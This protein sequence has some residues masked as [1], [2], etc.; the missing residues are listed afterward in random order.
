MV[1]D[2]SAVPVV[3][4]VAVA[5][6][7]SGTSVTLPGTVTAIENSPI[8]ARAPGYVARRYVDIGSRVK[9]G[10]LLAEV[11]AP[12]LDQQVEQARAEVAQASASLELAR[13]ELARWKSMM[14]DS[15]VTAAELDQKQAAFN[16]TTATL[17]SAKANLN[18]LEQ[19]QRY[20][21]VVAPFS[22]VITARN[23]DV[24]ALVGTAGAVSGQLPSGAGSATGS[25][26]QMARVDTLAIFISVPEDNSNAIR[27]GKVASVTIPA[28]P[29]DTL[30]G[31]ITR[32]SNALDPAA[33][34]LLTEV[35]VPNPKGAFLPGSYAQVTLALEQGTTGIR[36][37]AAGLIVRD[38]PPKVAVIG[39]DSIARYV[40]V[41]I[42]RDYGAWVEVK[43]GLSDGDLVVLNPPDDLK[44]GQKVRPK[45]QAPTDKP[46]PAPVPAGVKPGKP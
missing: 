30:R 16:T 27:V 10:Q 24:G 45:V 39:T 1:A 12:E 8:Y 37:P 15:A 34:T 4:V 19:L 35:D 13:Q 25:L 20:K 22:G 28:V 38:G 21:N 7:P 26:F 42:G 3:G 5:P 43:N 46:V 6:S 14:S 18:Q 33:R 23:V 17:N 2:N 41:T 29:G 31:V 32:T 44:E 36:L 9:K 11:E 40:T